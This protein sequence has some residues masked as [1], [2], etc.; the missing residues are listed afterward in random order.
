M[1]NILKVAFVTAAAAATF[2]YAGLKLDARPEEYPRQREDYQPWL[3]FAGVAGTLTAAA[4][5]A[6]FFYESDVYKAIQRNAALRKDQRL[7]RRQNPGTLR[8][9]GNAV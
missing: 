5:S 3:V 8:K 2:T 7:L 4:A 6:Y 1:R 9:K